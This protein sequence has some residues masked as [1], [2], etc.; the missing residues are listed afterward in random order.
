MW[1]PLSVQLSSARIGERLHALMPVTICSIR[2]IVSAPGFAPSSSAN[3]ETDERPET[4]HLPGEC[5]LGADRQGSA[6]S[7]RVSS[8]LRWAAPTCA[9]TAAPR[10]PRWGSYGVTGMTCSA[11]CKGGTDAV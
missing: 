5:S 4:L 11:A 6:G 3:E 1:L 2:P 8:A 7:A 9:V 10:F